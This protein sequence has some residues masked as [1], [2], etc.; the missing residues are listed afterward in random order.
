[1]A[2]LPPEREAYYA[3]ETRGRPQGSMDPTLFALAL[4][5]VS[6]WAA[7]VIFT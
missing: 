4:L 2:Q 3:D 6:V 7:V 5:A 1:M